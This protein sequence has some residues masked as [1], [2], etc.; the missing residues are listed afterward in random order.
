MGLRRAMV[1]VRELF[2]LWVVFLRIGMPIQA[3]K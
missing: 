2:C 3:A 1:W